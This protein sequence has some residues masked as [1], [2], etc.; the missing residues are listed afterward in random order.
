MINNVRGLR[1]I[2]LR[3]FYTI[4]KFNFSDPLKGKEVAEERFFFDKEE[5]K[6]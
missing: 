4:N 6:R 2:L 5:S 3:N 1:S